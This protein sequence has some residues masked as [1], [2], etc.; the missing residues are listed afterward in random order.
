MLPQGCLS[1]SDSMPPVT[2][3]YSDLGFDVERHREAFRR[4]A[5]LDMSESG[6]RAT[7]IAREAVFH[8]HP[9]CRFRI[10]STAEWEASKREEAARGAV[11]LVQLYHAEDPAA[12]EGVRSDVYRYFHRHFP[13]RCLEPKPE[14]DAA[15]DVY[16]ALFLPNP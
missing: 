14:P 8:R 2:D 7:L 11:D 1:M 10:G 13:G 5:E 3:K 9:T 12:V 16:I 6:V 15:S 4:F